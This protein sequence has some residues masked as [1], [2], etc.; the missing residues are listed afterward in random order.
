MHLRACLIIFAKEDSA[1]VI[2]LRAAPY[3]VIL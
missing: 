1:T 2:V 3:W